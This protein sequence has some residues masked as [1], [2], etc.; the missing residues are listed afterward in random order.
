MSVIVGSA[1][2]VAVTVVAN[3]FR[4][5]VVLM[6][7]IVRSGAVMPVRVSVRP[8]MRMVWRTFKRLTRRMHRFTHMLMSMGVIM[9]VVM[10][11]HASISMCMA[12]VMRGDGGERFFALH[13]AIGNPEVTTESN[14]LA[15]P[16][17]F[18]R[19]FS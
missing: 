16:L 3:R 13:A 2:I 10:I 4:R 17:A 5:M 7:M 9:S 11:V 19:S 1:V 12:L 18:F 8:G 15:S 14:P 6:R